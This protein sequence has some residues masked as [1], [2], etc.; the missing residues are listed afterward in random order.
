MSGRRA[1]VSGPSVGGH[2]GQRPATLCAQDVV[3]DLDARL[4]LVGERAI[5]MPRKELDLLAVLVGAA[6]RVVVRQELVDQVWG[7]HGAPVKSLEV[8]IRRLRR[9]IEPDPHHPRY[10][11]TV[12]GFGYVFDAVPF[13]V[14]FCPDASGRARSTGDVRADRHLP[15]CRQLPTPSRRLPG[16]SLGDPV[17]GEGA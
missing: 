17:D 7:P 9:R 15:C 3:V 14:V 11:R 5:A 4:V 10:I 1:V 2:G 8:H 6:G 16:G 13:P 12:R